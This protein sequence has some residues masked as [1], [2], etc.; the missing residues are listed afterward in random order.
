[1]PKTIELPT[2]E[3]SEVL[4]E[5]IDLVKV[6]KYA[7]AKAAGLSPSALNR[8]LM[9]DGTQMAAD[10]LFRTLE[11]NGLRVGLVL[12]GP[13]AAAPLQAKPSARLVPTPTERSVKSAVLS[14][15]LRIAADP[16]RP[17]KKPSTRVRR[18]EHG[19]AIP[20]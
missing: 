7:F 3:T 20:A 4:K 6:S 9:A 8:Y 14:P 15:P 5:A 2:L 19:A 1:M 10:K 11:A 18:Q 16:K 12:A 13:Q 17:A